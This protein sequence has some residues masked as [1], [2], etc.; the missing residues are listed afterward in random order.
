MDMHDGRSVYSPLTRWN[1]THLKARLVAMK[2]FASHMARHWSTDSLC[3]IGPAIL[4]L[5]LRDDRTR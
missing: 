5:S 1:S 3:W 4:R 2:A